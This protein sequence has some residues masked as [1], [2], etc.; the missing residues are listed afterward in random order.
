MPDWVHF[1]S[2]SG[3]FLFG[4]GRRCR[5]TKEKRQNDATLRQNFPK[6]RERGN[7]STRKH[8]MRH[9]ESTNTRK[10]ESTNAPNTNT[11]EHENTKSRTHEHT[12]TRKHEHTKTHKYEN[13]TY[14]STSVYLEKCHCASTSHW[15]ASP[16]IS[17]SQNISSTHT[18]LVPSLVVGGCC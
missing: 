11:R 6:E 12:K 1:G 16:Q 7:T 10:H 4:V 17:S 5:T 13:T 9:H 18:L 2:N 3:T 8:E 14:E 15:G